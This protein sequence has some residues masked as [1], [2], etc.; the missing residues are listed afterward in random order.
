MERRGA[1]IRVSSRDRDELA[2]RVA[3]HLPY[4]IVVDT[5]DVQ[6][7]PRQPALVVLEDDDAV[8]F[9]GLLT[10]SRWAGTNRRSGRLTELEA[11]GP[12]RLAEIAD[13]MPAATRRYARP[14]APASLY[15]P[16]T[17]RSSRVPSRALM[18]M[19]HLG[20]I[21]SSGCPADLTEGCRS[22]R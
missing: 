13:A 10:R 16:A 1:L 5:R 15:P 18:T 22:F 6:L 21:A 20:W 9:V 11:V 12:I 7:A 19:R 8:G 17:W 4:T 14:I 2:E 3:G